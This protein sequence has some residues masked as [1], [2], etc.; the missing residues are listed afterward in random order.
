MGIRRNSS[1]EA[2][3]GGDTKGKDEDIV[4]VKISRV[5]KIVL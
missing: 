3:Q 5:V 2:I 4:K 1:K